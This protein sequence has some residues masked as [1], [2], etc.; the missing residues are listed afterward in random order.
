VAHGA[1]VLDSNGMAKGGIRSPWIDVPT[2][3]LIGSGKGGTGIQAFLVLMGQSE[4]YDREKLA[5]LYPGGK[6]EYLARFT[7]SL[8]V[9]IA[10]GFI[11][12]ADRREIID[13]AAAAYARAS[14]N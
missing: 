11:L 3:R 1:L 6:T 7:A 9:A 2:S 4:R 5:E 14:G 12:R 8:D 10:K 13:L